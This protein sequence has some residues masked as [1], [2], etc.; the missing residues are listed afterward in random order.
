[1]IAGKIIDAQGSQSRFA[2]ARNSQTWVRGHGAHA[3]NP[4]AKS[5]AYRRRIPGVCLGRGVSAV[6]ATA[7]SC[8]GADIPSFFSKPASSAP[9]FVR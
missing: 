6:S 1:M 9:I 8:L 4:R 7:I 2:F 3:L 5:V